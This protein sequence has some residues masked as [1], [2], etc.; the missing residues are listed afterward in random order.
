M[1]INML[2]IRVS[3]Y[4][5]LF[6][7]AALLSVFALSSFSAAG[8]SAFERPWTF[9]DCLKYALEHNI[10][11]KKQEIAA[12]QGEAELEN[13]KMQRLPSLYGS[14]SQ[15]LSF[16]RGL[17]ADNTY[18]NANTGNT[19]FSL[20]AEVPVFQGFRVKN[21]IAVK[22]LNLK[23][24][25]ASL[26]QIKE[27]IA[28]ELAK[29]Y[30]QAL[31]DKQLL[32][33]ADNQA[34]ND[35]LQLYRMRGLYEVGKAGAADLARQK[36][37][38]YQ[39]LSQ[40]TQAGNNLRLSLLSLTQL[41]ELSDPEGFDIAEPEQR[42]EEISLS[43]SDIF[44]MA[45]ENRPRIQAQ[46]ARADAALASVKLAQSGWWPSISLSGGIGSNYYTSNMT[47]MPSFS[48]QMKNNFSQSL[49]L[50]LTLPI[51]D[52]LQTKNAVRNARLQYDYELYAL[53]ELAKGLYKEIQ[54]AYYNAL[55][56]DAKYRS[57]AQ[58]LAGAEEA[59]KL[60]SAK[61]ENGK[62]N[63]TEYNEAKTAYSKAQ[64]DLA[65]AR[66]E[67]LFQRR[68]LDFYRTGKLLL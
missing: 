46:N 54:Q 39:S 12:S 56:A 64:A 28:L 26:A 33:V 2:Q 52:R 15:N 19:Y 1:I 57:A 10:S 30:V 32:Q 68:L 67:R 49:G 66:Y 25:Q 16:G 44:C 45:R 41:L 38:Y 9:E 6:Q 29:A 22:T 42:L 14:A 3:L 53:D 37:A 4:K 55:S 59:Y 60:M 48:R 63:I 20:G 51:F 62:A 58:S 27:D 7:L 5:S 43:P 17:T 36:A 18:A 31:Y 40:K 47:K 8:L 34:L 21:D 13:A 50:T 35:S 61:Y 65:Q 23:A 24:A 11:V